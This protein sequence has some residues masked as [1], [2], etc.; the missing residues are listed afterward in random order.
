MKWKDSYHIYAAVTIVFWSL[1]YVLT[2]IALQYF[3]PLPL[4]F[5]RYAVATGVLLLIAL[6][7][8]M[9]LPKG[10]D[11]KWF[12]LSGA[13]GFFFYMIFFNVGCKTVN[14]STSSVIIATVPVMTALF[15]RLIY[16]EKL[17]GFQWI[18]ILTAFAGVN[19]LA[20]MDG[21][22]T[23][24]SGIL[25][26]LLAAVTLGFYN[27]LQRKLTKSYS[28]LQT[29]AFSIFIGTLFLSVFSADGVTELE[30]APK[31][32]I[33]CVLVMGIFSSAIA[34]AAWAQAFAKA[35]KASSVSNYMFF[36][37][38]LTTLLGFAMA[39]EKPDFAT[40]AG[41]MV[42]LAGVFLFYFGESIKN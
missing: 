13:A 25:W 15:A 18:A 29:T 37:P 30:S 11:M 34:Y 21:S 27:L 31:T 20:F 8:K 3:S 42:I 35:K 36:T 4:G 7:T 33:S 6:K 22:F 24:N 9:P 39:G 16:G 28:A 1:A 10:T 12:L 5:L 19:L 40:I 38:F 41:G 26:L 17:K 14:A 32:M 23:V 2:R